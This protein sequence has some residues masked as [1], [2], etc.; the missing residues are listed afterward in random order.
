MTCIAVSH[1]SPQAT[2]KW[3]DMLGGAWN[4]RV[5]VDEDRAVYAAWGLGTGSVWYLFNPTTQVQ[6]WREK[7]WLGEKVAEA[8]QRRGTVQSDRGRPRAGPGAAA[9][10]G[11]AND[12]DDASNILGNKWQEAGAFAIDG[13]G[14]VVW[15]GKAQRADDVMDLDE[16]A[17]LLCM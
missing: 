2:R 16:A 17:R 8:V 9:G 6:G 12:D 5:V 11:D 7:G 1:S 3:I 10:E 14:T 4:V 13:R 15:G